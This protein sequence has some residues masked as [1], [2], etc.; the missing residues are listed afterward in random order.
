MQGETGE[1]ILTITCKFSTD[2]LDVRLSR[3]AQSWLDRRYSQKYGISEHFL[4]W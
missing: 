2:L 1:K 4:W 3:L